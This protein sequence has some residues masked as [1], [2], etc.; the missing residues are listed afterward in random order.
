MLKDDIN[1]LINN[2]T[3]AAKLSDSLINIDI[4]R[5][6]IIQKKLADMAIAD[7]LRKSKDTELKTKGQADKPYKAPAAPPLFTP[8]LIPVDEGEKPSAREPDM[9]GREMR[10][11]GGR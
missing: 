6:E 5:I 11:R 8:P 10:G 9:G 2:L 7:Y 3:V 1:L 4:K